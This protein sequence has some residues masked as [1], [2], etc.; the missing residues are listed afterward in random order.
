[1]KL[2][3]KVFATVLSVAMMVSSLSGTNLGQMN[4]AKAAGKLSINKKKLTLT[5]GKKA[6]LKI[7]NAGKKL[8]GHQIRKRLQRYQKRVSLLL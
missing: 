1:M 3:K 7:K 2:H 4:V 6:T 8:P 5:V